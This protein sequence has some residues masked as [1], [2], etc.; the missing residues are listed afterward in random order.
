MISK[1]YAT[2][3][4][5]DRPVQTHYRTAGAGAPLVMLHPSPMSS[6]FLAPVIESVEEFATV[7]APDT[8]GYGQSDPLPEPPEDL[9]AYVDWLRRLLDVLGVRRSGVYGSA[10]GAQIAIEFARAHPDRVDYLLLENVVHFSDEDRARIMK[11]YF[12]SLEPRADGSHLQMAWTMADALFRRF[13]WFDESDEAAVGMANPPLE[14]VHAVT[15]AYLDAGPDYDRA[16]RAAFMNEKIENIQAVER[17]TYIMRWPGS[18][19]RR[20]ADRFDD[21]AW[22]DHFHMVH[23][24]PSA[25]DR[26]SA[27]RNLVRSLGPAGPSTD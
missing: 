22:P 14:L 1:A 15:L 24:G 11:D 8:P 20:Y 17:P 7:I 6:A 10:T 9:A 27:L 25:P 26:L 13:P 16:Y 2:L 18:M 19:L 23:C 21:F 12:P 3:Q 5:G 4:L